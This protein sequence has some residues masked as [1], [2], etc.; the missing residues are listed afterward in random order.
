MIFTQIDFP[1]SKEAISSIAP[2]PPVPSVT[3]VSQRPWDDIDFEILNNG[4]RQGGAWKP[5]GT[6]LI[7]EKVRSK[8]SKYDMFAGYL[9]LKKLL[10]QD[11]APAEG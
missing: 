8:L 7:K 4:Y 9:D 10:P 3:S 5:P 2:S 6:T 11:S 1:F